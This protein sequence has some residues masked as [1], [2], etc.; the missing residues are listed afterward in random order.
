[1]KIML[2]I[3]E[4]RLELFKLIVLVDRGASNS[5]RY[6]YVPESGL[7]ELAAT[8]MFVGSNP[9]VLSKNKLKVFV[10]KLV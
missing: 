6:E 3:P 1:M 7:R 8:Q 9:T 4:Y 5:T 10:K 2:L